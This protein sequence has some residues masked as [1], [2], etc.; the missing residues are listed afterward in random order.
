MGLWGEVLEIG[1]A[2]HFLAS[3]ECLPTPMAD[4][5]GAGEHH[6]SACAKVAGRFREESDGGLGRGPERG[7]D[8]KAGDS[9]RP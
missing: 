8:P 7:L 6:I 4:P 3:P 5:A 9:G 1:Q 2:P